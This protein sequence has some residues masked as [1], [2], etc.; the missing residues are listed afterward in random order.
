MRNFPDGLEKKCGIGLQNAF[1]HSNGQE[2]QNQ[3]PH[4]NESSVHRT[5]ARLGVHRGNQALA[6]IRRSQ[7]VSLRNSSG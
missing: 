1:Y 6:Q 7:S 3:V 5:P 2:H 4:Y